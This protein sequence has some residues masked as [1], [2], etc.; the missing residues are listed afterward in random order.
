MKSLSR[1]KKAFWLFVAPSGILFTVFFLVPLVL[2][3]VLSFTDY[4]GWKH[5]SFVGMENYGKVL[6][7]AA[8]YSAMGKTLIYTLVNLPFKVGI[9]L[10]LAVAL[11]SERV[12]LKTLTRT[13]IYIP[14][15]LSSLVVGITINWMFSQEYGLINFIIQQLGGAPVEWG[16]HLGLATFVI[17]VAGCWASTGFFMLIYIAALNNIPKEIYESGLIDGANAVQRFFKITIPMLAPAT[18]LVVLL[19]TV[20]LLKEYTLVQGITQGGPG[21]AT[22]FIVQYIF[23]KGFSQNMYGYATAISFIVMI[24][25]AL[26]AYAQFRV[27][28]GGEVDK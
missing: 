7:D 10:L 22:T 8:F 6:Q 19:S 15:L 5:I 25:F 17:S 1:Q 20:N 28:E 24:V 26:I 27:N 12:R 9:P 14:V 3:V 2:N 21:T 13:A 11:T 18:F 23:D 4:D 16:S